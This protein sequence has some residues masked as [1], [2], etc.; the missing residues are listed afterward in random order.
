MYGLGA[1]ALDCAAIERVYRIKQR[2]ADKPLSI[3]IADRQDLAKW[4]TGITAGAAFL[5]ERFWPGRVTFVFLAKNT[6]PQELLG[7]TGRIGIRLPAHR[8]AQAL[9]EAF[10]RPLTA[11]SANLSGRPGSVSVGDLPP[12]MLRQLDLVL[13]AGSLPGGSGSTVVDLTSDAPVVLREGVVPAAEIHR[14][15]QARPA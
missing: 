11:T 12:E 13:D 3:L 9:V 10:G 14:A 8:V 7:G 4:A 15:W 1:N 6:L 2:P 5:M